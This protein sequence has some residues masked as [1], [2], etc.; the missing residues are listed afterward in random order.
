MAVTND[1]ATDRRVLR[2][3]AT[4]REAG[5]AVS[6]VGRN[7][8]STS[9]SRGWR[10]YLE[11]NIGLRRK[12]LE[13]SPDVVWA[14]DTDTL[15]GSWLAC[16]SLAHTPFRKRKKMRLVMDAHELF[17]EVPEIQ[18]KP[19]VKWVWRTIESLL[20]PRC[21]ALLTVCQSVA[22]YYSNLYGVKMAV[23]RNVPDN[24]T[25][26]IESDA[27][28]G[29]PDNSSSLIPASSLKTLLYQGRVN[30]GRGVDWAIDALEWLPECRLVV[31][32]DGDLLE[33]M[34][35]YA[36]DK[37]W[38]DRVMFLG[39][40]MPDE[41]VR[42]T[43]QADV[44]LVM[45]EDMGLNYHYALPNRIGDFVQAG[46]PIVVSNLPEMAAV[47]RKFKVG[48]VIEMNK[49]ESEVRNSYAR[50]LARTVQMVL[51]KG[52][53]GYDFSEARSDMDWNKEKNKLLEC[54][55]A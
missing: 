19:F 45:L 5:Y 1:L 28:V 26:R 34:K 2:H 31:A 52:R 12:L 24:V 23:V 29:T 40:M 43:P 54:V 18:N 49:E 46:V 4:L 16:F 8:V 53:G 48:E 20:M 6:L 47:V 30:L 25:A 55:N 39:R 37:P 27:S 35:A 17:S 32:G 14:N 41:L 50:A 7:E 10:F 36:A 15:L 51:A 38:R 33:E 21:D 11:F 3:A 44:G 9:H 13:L 22:D 42:L